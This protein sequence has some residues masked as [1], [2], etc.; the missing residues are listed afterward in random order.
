MVSGLSVLRFS[1]LYKGHPSG[2]IHTQKSLQAAHLCRPNTRERKG[3]TTSIAAL[4]SILVELIFCCD[5]RCRLINPDILMRSPYVI[6][7]KRQGGGTEGVQGLN[8]EV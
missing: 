2:T 6:K 3:T 8:P 4:K 1:P 5:T 7:Q